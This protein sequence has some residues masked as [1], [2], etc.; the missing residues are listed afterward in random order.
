M[1]NENN[2]EMLKWKNIN[3]L[4]LELALFIV[5]SYQENENSHLDVIPHE[6]LKVYKMSI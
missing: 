6:N 1:L 3:L 5:L 2:N 4:L